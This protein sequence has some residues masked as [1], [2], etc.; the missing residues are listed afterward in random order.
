MPV[1]G[2]VGRKEMI[3]SFEQIGVHQEYIDAVLQYGG[4]PV[5]LTYG[6]SWTRKEKKRM[7]QWLKRCDG[8]VIPG[9]DKPIDFDYYVLDYAVKHHVPLLGICL[10]MQ[11]M[12]TYR[13]DDDLVP[14]GTKEHDKK[15]MQYVHEVHIDQ[16]SHLFSYL[17]NKS[18]ILV[19]SRHVEK[20]VRGGI[21]QVVGKSL[22]DIIEAVENNY[23]PFQIGV[24]WHPE[25]M[26]SYD[27]CSQKLWKSFIDCCKKK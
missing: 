24:Q 11:V 2:I 16:N 1:I 4:D 19:N 14:I 17:G 27:K 5:L 10:G 3:D 15:N 8:I 26:I 9:G 7:D 6:S 12:G 23:H 20:I 21:F 18:T 22:D 25:S 13:S